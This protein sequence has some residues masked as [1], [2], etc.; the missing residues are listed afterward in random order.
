MS[1]RITADSETMISFSDSLAEWLSIENVSIG[2]TCYQTGQL[3]LIGMEPT[4]AVSLSEANF[5]QAMGLHCDPD[6]IYLSTFNM[7]WRL[8]NILGKGEL[9]DGK[10]DRLY[11]P[12]NAHT[13]GDIDIHELRLDQH[14]NPVFVNTCYSC[15]A[16]LDPVHSFHPIWRP[17]FISELVPEH[18]CH[19]NGMCVVDGAPIYVTAISHA[20]EPDGWRGHRA[21]TGVLVDVT[22]N[23]IVVHGLS[24][25]HSPRMYSGSLWI[26]ES[27][28]GHLLQIDSTTYER[29]DIA[30][31]PG[32]LRGLDFHDGFA[33]VGMSLGRDAGFAGLAMEETLKRRELTPWC[34]VQIIDILR[35]EV[36]AWIRFE[37]KIRELF[38]VCI[39]RGVRC[40]K[41]LDPMEGARVITPGQ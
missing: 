5:G 13:V 36:A 25:P 38:E 40:P 22:T 15:L 2:L 33:V 6:R 37:G 18:R 14:G 10:H 12:R 8:E 20:D 24:M 4:G 23:E 32:F 17:L 3:L 27:G 34:G 30:F 19:L 41:V 28:R 31:C 9:S 11:I 35:G 29:E 16:T 7:V 21:E 26:V 39:I 1:S